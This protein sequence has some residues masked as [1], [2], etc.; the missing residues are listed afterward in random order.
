[1]R[2]V[3]TT[4][5]IHTSPERVISA[6]TGPAMLWDW[7]GVE[8]TLIDKK[9]GDI[10][11]LTWNISDKGFGYVSTGIIK[12]YRSNEELIIKNYAYLNPEKSILGPMSLIINVKQKDNISEIYLCQDSYRSGEDWG[13]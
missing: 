3:E 13:W 5:D 4:R 2:K 9:V 7:W 1:M 10:Y 12:S 11:R 6:F 8:R